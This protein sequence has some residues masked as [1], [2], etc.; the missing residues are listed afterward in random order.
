MHPLPPPRPDLGQAHARPSVQTRLS[1]AA[2]P[3]PSNPQPLPHATFAVS[4]LLTDGRK[5]R[6]HRGGKKKRNR[7]QSF[8]APSETSTLPSLVESPVND[9]LLE[10]PANNSA[11]G[12]RLC[13]RQQSSGNLS[14]T[15]LESDA[16]LDHRYDPQTLNIG[17]FLTPTLETHLLCAL[18]A[19]AGLDST[20]LDH[21]AREPH[22]M[23]R[24]STSAGVE[25]HT[26]GERST[27]ARS[28]SLLVMMKRMVETQMIGLLSCPAIQHQLRQTKIS[29]FMAQTERYLV[30]RGTLGALP[31]PD[32]K[33]RACIG[34]NP[35]QDLRIKNTT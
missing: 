9:P 21:I 15:S 1:F 20:L 14:S 35:F 5:K 26:P 24:Q 30:C 28:M 33:E 22:Q 25:D 32:D 13:R 18:A 16:L 10:V 29:A 23:L 3:A 17:K 34:S 4:Q 27:V 2:A 8:A 31:L 19:I 11:Q 12:G 7:R 6:K